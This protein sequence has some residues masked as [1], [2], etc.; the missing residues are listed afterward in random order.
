MKNILQ[1]FRKSSHRFVQLNCLL[2]RGT[3]DFPDEKIIEQ[4]LYSTNERLRNTNVHILFRICTL[5][6]FRIF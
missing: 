6:I 3:I 1:L 5:C 2:N 4:D